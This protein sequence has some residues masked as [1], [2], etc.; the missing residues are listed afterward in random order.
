MSI[1]IFKLLDLV[2][3]GHVIIIERMSNPQ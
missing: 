1:I 3:I 2:W